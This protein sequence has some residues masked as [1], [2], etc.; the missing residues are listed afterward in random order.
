MFATCRRLR[1]LERAAPALLSDVRGVALASP[2]QAARLARWL[3][4]RRSSVRQLQ[5]T[6]RFDDKLGAS[7]PLLVG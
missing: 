3:H 4:E 2:L 6:L 7:L 5:A 1:A